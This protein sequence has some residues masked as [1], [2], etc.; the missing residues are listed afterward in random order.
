[1]SSGAVGSVKRVRNPVEA[2]RAVMERTEHALLVGEE[3]TAWAEAQGLQMEDEVSAHSTSTTQHALFV[4]S[5]VFD[6]VFS[7]PRIVLAYQ[8]IVNS[9]EIYLQTNGRDCYLLNIPD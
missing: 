9:C 1:M 4:D 2:A 8:K 6:T 5:S 3:A 7:W